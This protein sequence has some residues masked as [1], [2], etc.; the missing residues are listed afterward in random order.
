[1][2]YSLVDKYKA[3]KAEQYKD[4]PQWYP[5]KEDSLYFNI[6]IHIHGNDTL[7]TIFGSP[8]EEYYCMYDV[9]N[10]AGSTEFIIRKDS[11]FLIKRGKESIVLYMEDP[12]QRPFL[13][14]LINPTTPT[15]VRDYVI[16]FSPKEYLDI[17]SCTY[18]YH[19]DSFFEFVKPTL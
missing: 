16:N 12:E 4:Y 7:L 1:M 19:Q 5:F 6:A 17:N 15:D 10:K 11:V 3:Y 18:I 2:I 14:L 8:H 9:I 13:N